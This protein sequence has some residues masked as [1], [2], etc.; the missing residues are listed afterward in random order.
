MCVIIHAAPKQ[1]IEKKILQNCYDRNS[2]GWGIMWAD[3]GKIF[4]AKDVSSFDAFYKI[5]INDVPRHAQRGVHFRIRTHGGKNKKN[6]H[7]FQPNKDVALMH[8][9]V[10]SSMPLIESEMS[11]TYNFCEYEVAP[12]IAG[13]TNFMEDEDFKKLME[14]NEVTGSS[15]LL[16]IDAEGNSLRINERM[17]HK[18]EGIYFSNSYSLNAP[19]KAEN[20]T[21]NHLQNMHNHHTGFVANTNIN[22]SSSVSSGALNSAY[23]GYGYD[24]PDYD[25]DGWPAETDKKLIGFRKTETTITKDTTMFIET[26][27]KS[28]ERIVCDLFA[29]NKTVEEG[30][31]YLASKEA[32][33]AEKVRLEQEELEE[34]LGGEVVDPFPKAVQSGEELEDEEED[35]T[36][37]SDYELSLDSIM[38]MSFAELWEDIEAFP[39]AYASAFRELISTCASAGIFKIDSVPSNTGII[40]NA[41]TG[42]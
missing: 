38:E 7:P 31:A 41:K 20:R 18:H 42:N 37:D 36:D 35:D 12:L 39:K 34:A 10:I 8:N 14:M 40:L 5:W 28:D 24:S 11:D 16:F 17:W 21:Y 26:T 13:W 1:T 29:G 2:D 4:T 6:C 33:T 9:G 27:T 30:E 23:A 3:E 32:E 22:K 15:K 19:Y 25:E